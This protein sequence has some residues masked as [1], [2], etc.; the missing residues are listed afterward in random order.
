M[1]RP[2]IGPARAQAVPCR[3]GVQYEPSFRT[4][5]RAVRDQHRMMRSGCGFRGAG[6]EG[7][8]DLRS[9]PH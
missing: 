4:E 2:S 8:H 7:S 9:Q 1:S 5:R 6:A 3:E